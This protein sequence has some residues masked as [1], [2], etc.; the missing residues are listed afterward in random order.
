M[1]S[2][3]LCTIAQRT[4]VSASPTCS[5]EGPAPV[6]QEAVGRAD[7]EADRRR[8]QVPDAEHL[9]QQRVDDERQQRVRDA[10]DAELD[11]L[12]ENHR[13]VQPLRDRRDAGPLGPLLIGSPAAI[14]TKDER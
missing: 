9:Q 3:Q 2:P 13:H 14:L 12:D 5:R 8:G 11:E 6:E 7:D 1:P 4:G 10:D